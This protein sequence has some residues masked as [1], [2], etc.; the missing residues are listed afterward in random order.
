MGIAQ[1]TAG[2]TLQTEL[3]LEEA[4]SLKEIWSCLPF[5]PKK[6]VPQKKNGTEIH[7]SVK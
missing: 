5:Q 6:T 4:G 7:K 2:A 3:S 1:Q